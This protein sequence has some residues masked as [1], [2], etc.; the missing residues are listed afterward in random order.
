MPAVL[1]A[2]RQRTVKYRVVLRVRT[3]LRWGGRNYGDRSQATHCPRGR[4]CRTLSLQRIWGLGGTA[5]R[6][7]LKDLSWLRGSAAWVPVE[8]ST[9]LLQSWSPWC[10]WRGD[11]RGVTRVGTWAVVAV[12][13]RGASS[14]DSMGARGA[15]RTPH[16]RTQG[17]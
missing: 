8:R 5:L 4:S 9:V 3:S 10:L 7:S 17:H 6:S 2:Q 11:G 12:C 13:V 15:K 1:R 16:A 14:S